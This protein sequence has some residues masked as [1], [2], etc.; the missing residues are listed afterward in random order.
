MT[1]AVNAKIEE[2]QKKIEDAEAKIKQVEAALG[3]RVGDAGDYAGYAEMDFEK[4]HPAL[5]KRLSE[6]ESR[7]KDLRGK[8]VLVSHP[9]SPSGSETQRSW[10]SFVACM[11]LKPLLGAPAKVSVLFQ[12]KSTC[13]DI[14]LVI[15]PARVIVE[16]QVENKPCNIKVEFGGVSLALTGGC[17]EL[18]ET[19]ETERPQVMVLGR[20]KASEHAITRWGETMNMQ[21]FFVRDGMIY[22]ARDR[23]LNGAMISAFYFM[24]KHANVTAFHQWDSNTGIFRLL[25]KWKTT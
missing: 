3:G 4:K 18:F 21:L 11:M 12:N 25:W 23:Q 16:R 8:K 20:D 13:E 1:T 17:S 24:D 19:D 6:L 22:E 10:Q 14:M 15:S 7:L 9:P 5:E 2:L